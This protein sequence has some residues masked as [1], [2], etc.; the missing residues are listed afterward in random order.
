[1]AKADFD[2]P[3]R[4]RGINYKQAGEGGDLQHGDRVLVRYGRFAGR[5]GRV[6]DVFRRE[7]AGRRYEVAWVRFDDRSVE[8]FDPKNL[9]KKSDQR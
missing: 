3:R 1:M 7:D 8:C 9:L 2:E 4:E 5:V 6:E